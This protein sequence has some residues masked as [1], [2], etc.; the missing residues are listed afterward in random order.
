MADDLDLAGV[1]GTWVAA[2]LALVALV[3]IVGP[4]LVWRASRTETQQAL[5]KVDAG[6]AESAGFVG[7]GIHVWPGIRLFRRV[8]APM[9]QHEPVL[10]NFTMSW[11]ENTRV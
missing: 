1:I 11:N 8:R 5:A 10:E 2:F 6:M 9:L 4:I 7:K 3:G